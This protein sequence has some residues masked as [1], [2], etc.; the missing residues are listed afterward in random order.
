MI[1]NLP[2]SDQA[3]MKV[4][5]RARNWSKHQYVGRP[6][7]VC[8]IAVPIEIA[9]AEVEV[10]AEPCNR[11][12]EA[13]DDPIVLRTATIIAEIPAEKPV[14]NIVGEVESLID[15]AFD[16]L[17]KTKKKRSKRKQEITPAVDFVADNAISQGN[18]SDN[19]LG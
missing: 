5:A 4:T 2:R 17:L 10:I 3:L 9:A 6:F 13:V 16:L 12:G 1:V 15:S 7:R 11:L 8:E 14:E 18:A 19:E